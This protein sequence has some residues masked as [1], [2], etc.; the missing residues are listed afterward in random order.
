MKKSGKSSQE[1]KSML[2][3]LY[4]VRKEIGSGAYSKVYLVNR[5]AD[6][7]KF[8]LKSIKM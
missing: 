6:S 1:E 4:K 2:K 7:K 5:R 8:A 3:K